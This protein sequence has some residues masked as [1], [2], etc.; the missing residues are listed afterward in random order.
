MSGMGLFKMGW[1]ETAKSMTSGF[2]NC[3]GLLSCSFTAKR[4]QVKMGGGGSQS[5]GGFGSDDVPR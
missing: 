4:W 2:S 1:F 5:H 3:Q